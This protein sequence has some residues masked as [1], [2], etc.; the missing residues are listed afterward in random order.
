[1]ICTRRVLVSDHTI[2]RQRGAGTHEEDAGEQQSCREDDCEEEEPRF[3]GLERRRTRGEGTEQAGYGGNVSA[4]ASS[5]A[6]ADGC[7]EPRAPV[8][9]APV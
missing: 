8:R 2:C 7:G 6:A 9:R 4:S 3:A 5:P 1:M